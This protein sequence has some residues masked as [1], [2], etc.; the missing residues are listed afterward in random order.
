MKFR[1]YRTWHRP[2]S[3]CQ[4]VAIILLS[5]VIASGCANDNKGRGNRAAAGVQNPIT[6]E[7]NRTGT[8][9]WRLTNPA[10]HREIEGYASATS[11]NRGEAIRLYVNTD[12][13]A[14]TL[15]VFRMGWYQGLGS[16]KVFGPVRVH[17]T[18]QLMPVRDPQTGL[19]DCDWK[20]PYLLN[21]VADADGT[22]WTSGVYLAKLSTSDTQQQ[23]YII[24]VV[25]DDARHSDLVLQLPMTTYQAYNF[26]G[27]K[28][29][30]PASSGDELPW[31][32][33]NGTPAVKVSFN[34]PY[35]GSTNPL[36]AY[37]VGAGDF[38]TNTQPVMRG[39]PISSAGWDY[40]LVRWLE[41]EGYDL[42]YV[43][44]LDTHTSPELLN[45]HKAF[46]SVGHDEY[47]SWSMRDNLKA[48]RDAGVNL[49]FFGA[50][51]MYW[52]VRFETS[53]V[54]QAPNRVMVAYKDRA[55][56][57]YSSDSD[58]ANDRLI[59]VR[60]HSDP[61]DRPEDRMVGMHYVLDPANG[62][63]VISNASHWVF[64]HTGLENGSRLT[65]LLG[66]EVDGA[67]DQ[68]PPSTEILAT[69]KAVDI[70]DASHVA[71]SN[72]TLYSTAKGALVF[73]TGSMQWSWGLDDFNVPAL[74]A[75]RLNTAAMQITRN[76]LARFIAVHK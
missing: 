18:H 16:R 76:V 17:A 72:M 27:G 21:T 23:S 40:N 31:G 35:V 45:P 42:S 33:V 71:N 44:S 62:D 38:L 64:E 6:A 19:V 49:A 10:M 14:Y 65:G 2:G 58:P 55:K 63:I 37:G 69:S 70:G 11:V 26:W 43:T 74:R 24:F 20:N 47:W 12:D 56:D 67:S 1:I 29:L 66:Y 50:N 75:S 52:Q 4:P 32:S 39:Y 73:A 36:A 9:E 46:L 30:Y 59:T 68:P 34:R 8:E 60:W 57:P 25:R 53:P 61:V 22:P 3:W 15:E 28:S 54:T 7:N 5:I 51:A 48:A 13:P 41:R